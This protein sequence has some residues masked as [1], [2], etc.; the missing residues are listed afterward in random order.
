MKKLII[1]ILI[2]VGL[3]GCGEQTPMQKLE[4]DIRYYD[5]NNVF[6]GKEHDANTKLWNEA[7]Q[8]CKGKNEKPN[9]APVMEMFVISNG[10][11]K[12]PAYGT[13]G[14]ALTIPEK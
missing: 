11:T 6:W 8:Y 10:S 7:L 14:N 2:S 4:S 5:M 12:V 9:C 1:F 3:S 13:S